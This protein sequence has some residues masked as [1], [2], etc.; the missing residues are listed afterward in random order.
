MSFVKQIFRC[1]VCNNPYFDYQQAMCNP[2]KEIIEV[3]KATS[4][5]CKKRKTSSSKDNVKKL[6]IDLLEESDGDI[7]TSN[8][9]ND[10][11]NDNANDND[12]VNSNGNDNVKPASINNTDNEVVVNNNTE[13]NYEYYDNNDDLD[14]YDYD[15]Y[16]YNNDIDNEN[17]K[18]ADNNNDN[19]DNNNHSN[20]DNDDDDDEKCFICN[21]N[22]KGL[23]IDDK[24]N[25]MLECLDQYEFSQSNSKITTEHENINDDDVGLR[26]QTF[27][28]VICD[29]N[30]SS[31]GSNIILINRNYY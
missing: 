31:K 26:N 19:G 1:I 15:E 17:S 10:D 6:C 11:A 24:D 9:V 13:N 20:D 8:N 3:S 30:L 21:Q 29:Q 4:P 5:E 2:C 7:F 25:H 18:T 23:S 22:L 28:C 14:F 27:F 16:N 12:N